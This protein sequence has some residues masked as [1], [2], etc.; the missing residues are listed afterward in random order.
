MLT[1]R[2]N[3]V[4]RLRDDPLVVQI[5]REIT[6]KNVNLLVE[7][8]LRLK[9][10]VMMKNVDSSD[11]KA[12]RLF[13]AGTRVYFRFDEHPGFNLMAYRGYYQGKSFGFSLVVDWELKPRNVALKEVVAKALMAY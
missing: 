5:N 8:Y 1:L 10:D 9:H 12:Y 2:N 6:G 7:G 11:D 13:K 3:V 4:K